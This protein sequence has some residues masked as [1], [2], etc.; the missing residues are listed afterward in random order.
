MEVSY[1]KVFSQTKKL[2]LLFIE[3]DENFKKETNEIFKELFCKVDLAEN[4]EIGLEKYLS[5]YQKQDKYYDIVITDINLPQKN[6]IELIKQIYKINEHQPIIVLSAHNESNYL[7]ELINIKIEQ[8]LIKPLDYNKILEVFFNVSSKILKE[9]IKE[10]SNF[11]TNLIKLNNDFLWNKKD[12]VLYHKNKNIKLTKK[13]I[14][15]MQLFIKNGSK[16]STTQEISDA[17]WNRKTDLKTK[18]DLK[19]LISRFRKKIHPITIES[20]YGLGYKLVF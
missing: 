15:L 9:D 13:E 12:F 16:I 14:L 2:T 20:V 7:L 4:A 10:N 17:L 6:G 18:S 19:P 1:A 11:E 5:H 8:F 3:D